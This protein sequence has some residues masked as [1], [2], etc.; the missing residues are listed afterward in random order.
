MIFGLGGCVDDSQN[1][2]CSALADSAFGLASAIYLSALWRFYLSA[3]WRF[4]YSMTIGS[5]KSCLLHPAFIT[6]TLQKKQ[7]KTPRIF[8]HII[9]TYFNISKI[10]NSQHVGNYRTPQIHNLCFVFFVFFQIWWVKNTKTIG[11]SE[12]FQKQ[13]EFY[14][15]GI[16]INL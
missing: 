16:L 13:T 15:G 2:L 1:Q 3:V 8:K 10:P 11:I 14:D 6:N 12:R 9:F 4:G 7:E 5:T